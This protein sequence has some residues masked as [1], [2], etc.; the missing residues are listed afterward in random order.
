[1]G[2]KSVPSEEP[3]GRPL[4]QLTREGTFGPHSNLLFL[5]MT[6]TKPWTVNTLREYMEKL[7]M[8]RGYLEWQEE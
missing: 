4:K 7:L 3:P 6:M 5:D 8:E 2:S 1:M